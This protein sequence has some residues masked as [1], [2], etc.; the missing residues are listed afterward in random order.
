MFTGIHFIPA[1][2]KIAQRRDG[3]AALKRLGG[4]TWLGGL[5][6]RHPRRPEIEHRHVGL[7]D[8][9]ALDRGHGHPEHSSVDLG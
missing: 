4:G 9:A 8:R 3:S 5:R 6:H 7:D 1:D 2:T